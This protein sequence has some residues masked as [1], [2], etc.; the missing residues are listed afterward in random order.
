MAIVKQELLLNGSSIQDFDAKYRAFGIPVFE[1]VAVHRDFI[2]LIYNCVKPE[3]IAFVKHKFT[4]GTK[5]VYSLYGDGVLLARFR[6]DKLVKLSLPGVKKL[7]NNYFLSTSGVQY[8]EYANFPDLVC[9]NEGCM[10][11]AW[12]LK[13]MYTP[14]L[15]TTGEEFGYNCDSLETFFGPE[16]KLFGNYSLINARNLRVFYAPKFTNPGVRCLCNNEQ[17]KSMSM[18]RIKKLPAYFMYA[19]TTLGQENINAP[20]LETVSPTCAEVFF[21]VMFAN[22]VRKINR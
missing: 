22:K 10:S 6:D 5:D 2:D 12:E 20:K 15:K 1:N 13:F 17:M 4:D 18:A 7:D 21:D 3:K 8:I 19:N 14:K 16:L 11:Q 9:A